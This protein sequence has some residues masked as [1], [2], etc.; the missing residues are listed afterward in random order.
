MVN[1]LGLA[2]SVSYFLRVQ[3]N[4]DMLNDAPFSMCSRSSFFLIG[5][6]LGFCASDQAATSCRDAFCEVDKEPL[7]GRDCTAA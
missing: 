5:S 7:A 3:A 4:L 1:A 2:Q 6:R